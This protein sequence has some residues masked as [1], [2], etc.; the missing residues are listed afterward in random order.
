MK[1]VS[2][3]RGDRDRVGV[4][5]DGGV[6]DLSDTFFA[7]TTFGDVGAVFRADA[8]DRLREAA[9]GVPASFALDD[10]VFRLPIPNPGKI[11]CVGRNY[12]AYHEVAED[13]KAPEWP[14][15]FGRFVDSF[16]A[17]GEPILKPREGEHLDYEGELAAVIG[18]AGR[19]IPEAEALSHIGGYTCLN[20]G[21]VR[22]W[23]GRGRQNTP[24][25]NF[26]HSGAI[27][28][29]VVTADEIPDPNALHILT[30]VN[31]EVRQD[32]GTDLMIFKIPY[33][34]SYI[35]QFTPLS[36]GDI[37]ATGS[38]GGSAV[39]MDPQAWLRPGDRLEIEISGIGL[40]ANPIEAE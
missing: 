23:H 19:H 8:L 20:E 22:D 14:S 13:G 28:P 36:P 3:R 30:R 11:L 16:V 37:I 4:V 25:K 15:I 34:I 1:L 35:S 10:V 29:W 12:R 39:E 31:G 40:L 38:P 33:L 21:S 17:H 9:D 27:G 24:S 26:Y 7:G 18:K 5:V 6:A 2:F 32:G